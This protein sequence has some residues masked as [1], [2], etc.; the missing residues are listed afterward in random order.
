MT[1][2]YLKGNLYAVEFFYNLEKDG[3]KEFYSKEEITN[4]IK[5]AIINSQDCKRGKRRN[6]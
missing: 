2:E 5:K 6:D 1:K 3:M 4:A